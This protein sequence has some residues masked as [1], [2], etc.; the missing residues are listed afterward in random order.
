MYN[1]RKRSTAIVLPNL[2]G[3]NSKQSVIAN[4]VDGLDEVGRTRDFQEPD[5]L[6]ESI[7][8]DI[9]HEIASANQSADKLPRIL[10]DR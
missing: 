2:T 3:S 4:H 6:P 9:L 10:N 7:Q 1:C 8:Y 5:V